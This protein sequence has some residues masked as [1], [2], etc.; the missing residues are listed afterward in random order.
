MPPQLALLV[1]SLFVLFLLRLECK[2]ISGVSFALWIPT[3][4]F[5]LISSKPLAAWLNWGGPGVEAGSPL[6]QM[7]LILLLFS[8][9][10]I[11]IKRHFN[12]ESAIREN[13]WVIALLMY[14]C[15]SALWADFPEISLRR[16]IGQLVPVVMAFVILSDP[17]PKQ[18]LQSIF[19][20]AIYI[21]IPFSYLLIHY[22]PLTGRVYG[23]W[24]GALQWVGVT[25]QKNGLGRLCLVSASF[26]IWTFFARHRGENYAVAKYQKHLEFS[27]LMLTFWLMGGPQHNFSYSVTSNVALIMGLMCLI[28]LSLLKKWG[29]LPGQNLLMVALALIITYGTVTP[30]FGKLTLFDVTS[31][32][33]RSEDLTDRGLIWQELVPYAMEKPYFGHGIGG[34]VTGAG[35]VFQHELF[36]TSQAHSGYLSIILNYGF[37]GLLLFSVYLMSFIRKIQ[38]QLTRDFTWG[39]LMLAFLLMA[40]LHSISES[41]LVTFTNPMSAIILLFAFQPVQSR[42]T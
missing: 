21:L 16:T 41:T 13:I 2:Q 3:I 5:L 17:D 11:L 7:V 32:F 33:G 6:D 22:Y 15:V 26:L 9:L 24:S 4:W 10:L 8:G 34:F 19:R 20:R 27:L 31:T 35:R 1:C 36:Q 39:S 40:V 28:G 23:R 37:F 14:M 42:A 18:A 25:N 30:F 38:I 29:W 12:F